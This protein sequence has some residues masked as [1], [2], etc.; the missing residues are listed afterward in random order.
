[1]AAVA[2]RGG[3]SGGPDVAPPAAAEKKEPAP[4]SKSEP[5]PVALELPPICRGFSRTEETRLT[6]VFGDYAW[7]TGTPIGSVAVSPDGK[8]AV[9]GG[10]RVMKLIDLA[11]GAV[12]RD[13]AGHGEWTTAVAFSPSSTRAVS[14]G[15]D[16]LV[17]LW[18]VATGRELR[19]FKGHQGEVRTV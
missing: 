3:P 4:R 19:S 2:T 17:R 13:L 6:A 16:N 10:L 5:A 11:T 7:K 12:V 8:L 15:R 1:V 9:A 18:D 14:G